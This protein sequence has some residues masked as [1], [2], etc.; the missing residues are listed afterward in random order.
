MPE[1]QEHFIGTLYVAPS[2]ILIVFLSSMRG[3][4]QLSSAN[5]TL[6]EPLNVPFNADLNEIPT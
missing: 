1:I 6:N 2:N 4:F 5:V 3:D